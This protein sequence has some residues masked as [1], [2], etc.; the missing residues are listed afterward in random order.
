MI[1]KIIDNNGTGKLTIQLEE[2]KKF[3]TGWLEIKQTKEPTEEWKTFSKLRSL[4]NI[5]IDEFVERNNHQWS[6][7]QVEEEFKI[8]GKCSE[9]LERPTGFEKSLYMERFHIYT[10]SWSDNSFDDGIITLDMASKC[11]ELCLEFLRNSYPIIH[12]T[13]ILKYLEIKAAR[14]AINEQSTEYMG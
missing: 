5:L 13:H 4:W 11:F 8:I 9:M 14:N 10:I 1:G 6:R 3:K 7:N 2:Q 12:Q